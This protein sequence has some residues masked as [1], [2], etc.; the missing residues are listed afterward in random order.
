MTDGEVKTHYDSTLITSSEG[1]AFFQHVINELAMHPYMD[2]L[3]GL[4]DNGKPVGLYDLTGLPW[5]KWKVNQDA[6]CS[7][8]MNCPNLTK[9]YLSV[10]P[11]W[12]LQSSE[13]ADQQVFARG[14]NW[15]NSAVGL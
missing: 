4:V 13:P 1:I 2:E 14:S 5:Q 11:G 7:Y 10:A 15:Q 8:P 12:Q 3:F 9:I 6:V